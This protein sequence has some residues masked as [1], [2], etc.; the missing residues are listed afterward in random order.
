MVGSAAAPLAVVEDEPVTSK[1]LQELEDYLR[2]V[3]PPKSALR[4]F[5]C[6]GSP[7]DCE[8]ALIGYNPATGLTAD[9]WD[10][11]SSESGFDRVAWFETYKLERRVQPLKPGRTRRN[12]VSP[13][14]KRIELFVQG[15]K[16]YRCVETNLFLDASDDIAS[17]AGGES[18]LGSLLERLPALRLAV[19]HHES[20]ARFVRS[21][22]PLLRVEEVDHFA[23]RKPEWTDDAALAL[24]RRIRAQL[25]QGG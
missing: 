16:P 10:F 7:M 8:V 19:C 24:G 14:R 3:A 23:N 13:T 15:L 9:F 18:G 25:D 6:S 17:H 4:P 5:V 1:N 11:W 12:P 20:A 22:F 2:G 21:H